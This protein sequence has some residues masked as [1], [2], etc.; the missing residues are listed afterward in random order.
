MDP[1]IER[2][3]QRRAQAYHRVR[4]FAKA[5]DD[6]Q[7]LVGQDPYNV[8]VLSSWAWQLAT[9]PDAKYRNG[10]LALDL[11]ADIK[12]LDLDALAAAYAETGKYEEAI[13]T[14]GRAIERLNRAPEP[15]SQKATEQRSKRLREKQER[16]TTYRAR[17]PFRDE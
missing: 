2:V 8:S 14:Q 5:H 7:R 16:L 11:L 1:A 6:F 17:R 4:E 15:K 9:C 12:D 3:M 10:S 13:A